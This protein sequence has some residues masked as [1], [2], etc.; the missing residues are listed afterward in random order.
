MWFQIFTHTP[1]QCTLYAVVLVC[2]TGNTNI[3]VYIKTTFHSVTER[4]FDWKRKQRRQWRR[5][6]MK[7]EKTRFKWTEWTAAW[8]SVMVKMESEHHAGEN[9]VS[10]CQITMK[11]SKWENTIRINSAQKLE[12][13]YDESY[14]Y[15]PSISI[16]LMLDPSFCTFLSSIVPVVNDVDVESFYYYYFFFFGFCVVV[17]FVVV[18]VIVVWYA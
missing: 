13:L 12:I 7:K 5:T 8:F 16:S 14:Y 4:W 17:V 9:I 10:E 6:K 3:N 1:A 15:C 2:R 11:K 18:G